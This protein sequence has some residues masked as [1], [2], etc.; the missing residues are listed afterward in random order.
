MSTDE[1]INWWWCDDENY[2]FGHPFCPLITLTFLLVLFSFSTQTRSEQSTIATDRRAIQT[3]YIEAKQ[4]V[5]EKSCRCVVVSYFFLQQMIT[6]RNV[7][8]SLN[9]AKLLLSVGSLVL[10][11]LQWSFVLLHVQFICSPFGCQSC[12]ISLWRF[13]GKRHFYKTTEALR[14]PQI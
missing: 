7:K 4:V 9:G 11:Q 3:D 12:V 1:Q 13:A 10:P 6:C 8:I 14:W 2:S 5:Q